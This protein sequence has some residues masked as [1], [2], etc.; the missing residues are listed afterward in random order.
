V[1]SGYGIAPGQTDHAIR[2]LRCFIHGLALL[3]AASGFQWSNDPDESFTAMVNFID[4][5]L[6][7]V[8]GQRG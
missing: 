1:L 8:G 7:A 2:A 5:G 6:W 3:E 4:A